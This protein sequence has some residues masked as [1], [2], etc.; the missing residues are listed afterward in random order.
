MKKCKNCGIIQSDDNTIC[1]DCSSPLVSLLSEEENEQAEIA[2]K[3]RVDDM[4]ERTDEFYVSLRDRIMGYTCLGFI[5]VAL[6]LI[7]LAYHQYRQLSPEEVSQI[8]INDQTVTFP[9]EFEVPTPRMN[10]LKDV[11]NLGW[12]CILLSA[13]TCPLFLTPRFVWWVTTWKYRVYHGWET[14][15]SYYDTVSRKIVAGISFALGAGSLIYGWIL[16]L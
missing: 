15:P 13:M 2:L 3:K 5:V 12:I 9:Y 14:P 6:V 7:A 11:M 4:T 8:T 1:P 10:Q 16:F